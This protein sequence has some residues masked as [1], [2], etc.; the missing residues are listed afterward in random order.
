MNSN[1]ESFVS[2]RLSKHVLDHANIIN[3]RNNM[4]ASL[5][6]ITLT[7]ILIS[8]QSMSFAQSP[9]ASHIAAVVQAQKSAYAIRD[10][11]NGCQTPAADILGW[12]KSL[13][14]ECAY[15][16][17]PQ[18]QQRTAY[19]ILVNVSAET[20]A[21]WIETA[22]AEVLP[23]VG[24]C[25]QRVLNCGQVNSGMMFPISGNLMEDMG[26]GPWRN[27]F[28]RNGMTVRMP[29][30]PNGTESQISMD[31]QRELA[32]MADANIASIPSGLTRFWRTKPAQFAA[33]FPGEGVPVNVTNSEKRQKWLNIAR[34]E[35][36]SAL[37]KPNN[38]L[39]EAW[40]AAHKVTLAANNCPDDTDP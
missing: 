27:W 12:P 36:L 21:T 3:R 5:L 23:N 4:K 31:R 30:Q 35:F 33:R 2:D 14:R 22:C 11:P 26:G 18:G 10:A 20:I 40:V 13:L 29:N 24:T 6:L 17:G 28:F 7:L 34:T 16:V 37:T 25:F 9:T 8:T 19:V 38:R 1:V 32:L 15:V 39:L